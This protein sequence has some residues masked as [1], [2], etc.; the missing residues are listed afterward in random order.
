MKDATDLAGLEEFIG[1]YRHL[2]ELESSVHEKDRL[3]VLCIQ[4][5]ARLQ[6]RRE[7]ADASLVSGMLHIQKHADPAL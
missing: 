1:D 5:D 6:D 7:E 3:A 2:R 4:Q